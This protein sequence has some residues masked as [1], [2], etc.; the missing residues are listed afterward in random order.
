MIQEKIKREN[1]TE[2]PSVQAKATYVPPTPITINKSTNKVTDTAPI[3][4]DPSSYSKIGF[5]PT[6]KNVYTGKI[7]NT[8]Q[9]G[10]YATSV[11]DMSNGIKVAYQPRNEK[12]QIEVMYQ[13][14]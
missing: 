3:S 2:A 12:V 5:Q 6:A 9:D 8:P 4:L 1:L 11:I 7:Y 13:T 10:A 14:Q